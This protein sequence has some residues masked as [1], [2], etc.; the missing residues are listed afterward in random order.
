MAKIYTKTG[1]QG[2]TGLIG[3]QRVPKNH[4]RVEA[5][6]AVDE[7]NAL[8]GVILSNWEYF[9]HREEIEV[10]QSLLFEVGATLAGRHPQ[11]NHHPND[12]DVVH[13]EQLIDEL[14]S[15]LPP[16]TNF[17]LPGGTR[18]SA[19]LH[20]ARTVARRAERRTIT[21]GQ[22]QDIPGVVIRYLNRLSDYLFTLARAINRE[23][24][25]REVEW[26]PKQ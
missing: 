4:V 7:L 15:T 21:V 20:L 16:L 24:S 26:H 5:A 9:T 8:L 10:I 11:H 18:L 1:D 3:G 23:Q 25:K 13:L 12:K 14:T 17:I 2:H 6:G 19:H 22:H